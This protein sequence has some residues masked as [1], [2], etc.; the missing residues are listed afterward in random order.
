MDPVSITLGILPIFLSAVQ[1]FSIL[2]QK[3]H[4]LRHYRKEVEWLRTKVDVQAR[5][6]KGEIHHLVIDALDARKAQSL[7]RDDDH[8][9]WKNKDVEG[10]LAKHMGELSHEFI[11]AIRE[12][13]EALVQIQAKL[14]IFAPPDVTVNSAVPKI[15]LTTANS[16]SAVSPVQSYERQVSNCL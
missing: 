14:A 6:F 9:H 2:Q 8:A 16:V 11:R 10:T 4:S 3:I 1:G 5:C 13:L 7:I 12:V 15:A